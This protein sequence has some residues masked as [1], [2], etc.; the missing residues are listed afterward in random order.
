ME[1][2]KRLAPKVKDN[3][4]YE[5]TEKTTDQDFYGYRQKDGKIHLFGT[6][7][8]CIAKAFGKYLENCLGA[9]PFGIVLTFE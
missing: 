7:K 8:V 6:D 2:I 9:C 1:L 3:F 5:I 4:T